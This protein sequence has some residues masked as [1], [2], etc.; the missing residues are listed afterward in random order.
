MGEATE[1]KFDFEVVEEGELFG[2]VALE[3]SADVGRVSQV[4]RGVVVVGRHG[5]CDD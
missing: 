3:P 1:A 5:G 4:C 2:M